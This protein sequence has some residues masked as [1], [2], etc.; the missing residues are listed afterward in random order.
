MQATPRNSRYLLDT[1][2]IIR[3]LRGDP[4]AGRLMNHLFAVG[5][6]LTSAVTV[7]ETF[8][9]C[10][11]HEEEA[12]AAHLLD[13]VTPLDIDYRTA[14]VAG[15]LMRQ[16]SSVFGSDRA[17]ADALITAAAVVEGAVLVA[18][19]TR[20]FSRLPPG[21]VELLLLDQEAADWVASWGTTGRPEGLQL[22]RLRATTPRR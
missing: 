16:F 10:K 5:D 9:G 12:A 15:S 22:R 21:S 7:A 13:S 19:N 1:G 14:R 20:Q 18:L 6:L 17:A 2:I 11:S 8:R 4:R 3:E